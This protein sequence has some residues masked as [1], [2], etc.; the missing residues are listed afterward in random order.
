VI[1]TGIRPDAIILIDE[2]IDLPEKLFYGKMKI[3]R[4]AKKLGYLHILM[5]CLQQQ[6]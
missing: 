3:V 1:P 6:R 2:E 5:V 4:L